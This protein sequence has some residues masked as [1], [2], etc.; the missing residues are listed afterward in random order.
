[1]PEILCLM[2]FSDVNSVALFA[3]FRVDSAPEHAPEIVDSRVFHPC[4]L[5]PRF[6]PLSSGAAFYNLTFSTPAPW[7]RV[8]PLPRVPLPCFQRPPRDLSITIQ[9]PTTT[10]TKQPM[11]CVSILNN[12]YLSQQSSR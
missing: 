7:C 1:M 2:N 9:R 6:P 8:F 11:S 12:A 5:V 4:Y 3:A 10:L